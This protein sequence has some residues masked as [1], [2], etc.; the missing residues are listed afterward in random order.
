MLAT[1]ITL[2]TRLCLVI[3]TISSLTDQEVPRVAIL[4]FI[5]NY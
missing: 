4:I 1:I 5:F 2:I 3:L